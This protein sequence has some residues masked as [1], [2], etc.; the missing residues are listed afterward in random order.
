MMTSTAS[1]KQDAAPSASNTQPWDFILVS[2]K[3]D[4]EELSHV[5][6]HS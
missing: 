2:D 1:L 4:L 5:A 6:P 3:S